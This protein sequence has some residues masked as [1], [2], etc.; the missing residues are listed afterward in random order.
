MGM[1]KLV[2]YIYFFVYT[3]LMISISCAAAS[4]HGT[5]DDTE[6]FKPDSHEVTEVESAMLSSSDVAVDPSLPERLENGQHTW[7]A[8]KSE[9]LSVPLKILLFPPCLK[10]KSF[11]IYYASTPGNV[12]VLKEKVSDIACIQL[13]KQTSSNFYLSVCELNAIE[14]SYKKDAIKAHVRAYITAFMSDSF[15]VREGVVVSFVD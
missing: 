10:G 11:I 6:I 7:V 5:L 3:Y 13:Q 15:V 4:L 9:P 1:R 12:K 2:K 14:D 8:S